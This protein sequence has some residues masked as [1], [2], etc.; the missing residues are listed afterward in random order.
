MAEM[1]WTYELG[2]DPTP[3][4]API[5]DVL[6]KREHDRTRCPM[7]CTTGKFDYLVLLRWP[8]G[9][10]WRPDHEIPQDDPAKTRF[11]QSLVFK[12]EAVERLD[13][14]MEGKRPEDVH[15]FEITHNCESFKECSR[16]S[17]LICKEI[18][19]Y[20]I[21]SGDQEILL[22]ASHLSRLHLVP[23]LEAIYNRRVRIGNPGHKIRR[24]VMN[25]GIVIP[26]RGRIARPVIRSDNLEIGFFY[27]PFE[28]ERGRPTVFDAAADLDD[29]ESS[30]AEE[31]QAAAA[32]ESST[33]GPKACANYVI[34]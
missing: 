10:R 17:S 12:D 29:D 32:E 22:P 30:S 14:F 16:F 26:P 34:C 2:F 6:A 5:E 19:D 23:G 25:S 24:I 8:R 7:Q 28:N 3:I 11:E 21:Q 15:F 1:S 31:Y 9:Y 18:N 13:K 33:P 20:S 4:K 27:V